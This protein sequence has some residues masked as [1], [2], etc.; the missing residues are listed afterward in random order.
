VRS[1][2][3]RG[4]RSIIYYSNSHARDIA[5]RLVSSL[6]AAGLRARALTVDVKPEIRE[7]WIERRVKEGLDALVIN[8]QLVE[9]GLDLLWFPVVIW[10]QV[11]Y[12]TTTVR[13]A[14]RRSWRIGQ[15]QP[16]TVYHLVYGG[17]VQTAALGL[18][19]RKVHSSNLFDGDLSAGGLDEMVEDESLVALAKQLLEDAI[20]QDGGLEELFANREQVLK[21]DEAFIDQ[22]FSPELVTAR[23]AGFTPALFQASADAEEQAETLSRLLEEHER[24]RAEQNEKARRQAERRLQAVVESGQMLLFSEAA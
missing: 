2:K 11:N 23:P 8:A 1:E 16:V 22:A 21:T 17:T 4:R 7:S 9:T 20:P 18:I 15:R 14:S 10:A 3:A 24:L 5:P 6:C 19:A 13:Q 12:R